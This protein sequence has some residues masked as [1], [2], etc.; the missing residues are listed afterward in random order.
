MSHDDFAVETVPGLPAALPAGESL[1]WQGK[2]QWRSLAIRALHARKVA[3]YFLVLMLWS[4]GEA[5]MLKQGWSAALFAAGGQLALGTLA[6]ALLAGVAWLVART[7]I[8]SI[9]SERVVIRFGVALQFT[10]NLPFSSVEAAQMALHSDGT[11]DIP[12]GLNR[13]QQVSFFLL[14]PHVRPWHFWKVQPMLRGI[15]EPARVAALL[16]EALAAHRQRMRAAAPP[17]S[18]LTPTIAGAP[19]AGNLHRVRE[20]ALA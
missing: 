5:L 16:G 11:G 13:R 20:P 15:G 4:G 6:A 10:I 1:L 8:Y 17:S 2:P 14:W 19:S 9:T 18:V 3:I 7:T 12:L